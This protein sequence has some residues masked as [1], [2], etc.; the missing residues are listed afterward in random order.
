MTPCLSDLLKGSQCV[1]QFTPSTL[2]LGLGPTEVSSGDSVSDCQRVDFIP[3]VHG[4][5]HLCL[6]GEGEGQ[7]DV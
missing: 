6:Q 1:V 7:G 3:G 2:N 5:G 4:T